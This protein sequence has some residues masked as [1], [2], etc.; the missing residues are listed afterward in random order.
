MV[1]FCPCK[2]NQTIWKENGFFGEDFAQDQGCELDC[3]R[4]EVLCEEA[5]T[6]FSNSSFLFVDW[7]TVGNAEASLG[8]FSS[9]A[10]TKGQWFAE[11]FAARC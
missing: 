4:A 11:C 2:V 3:E 10:I 6:V 7:E 5:E 9:Q 8:V 1:H